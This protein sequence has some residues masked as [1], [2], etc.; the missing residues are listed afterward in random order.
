MG[1][2]MKKTLT[3]LAFAAVIALSLLASTGD[4]LANDENKGDATT[5]T[6]PLPIPTKGVT[7]EILPLGV[8]WER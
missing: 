1:D 2:D 5:W 3:R 4:A 8:T 6:G 7:W